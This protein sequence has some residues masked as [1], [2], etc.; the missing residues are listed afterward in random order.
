MLFEYPHPKN[1]NKNRINKPPSTSYYVG[2]SILIKFAKRDTILQ[3]FADQLGTVALD[4][5]AHIT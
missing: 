4:Y 2:A 3:S 5:C 1:K